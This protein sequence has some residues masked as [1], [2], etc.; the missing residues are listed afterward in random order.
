MSL[1]VVLMSFLLLLAFGLLPRGLDLCALN[2]RL[3]ISFCD[4]ESNGRPIL[5]RWTLSPASC[6]NSVDRREQTWLTLDHE[7][8]MLLARADDS[9]QWL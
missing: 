9:V 1:L 5:S 4:G 2:S 3:V 7:A 6:R 8:K